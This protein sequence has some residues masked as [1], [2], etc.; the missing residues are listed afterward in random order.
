M[1]LNDIP[2]LIAQVGFPMAIAIYMLGRTDKRL[3]ALTQSLQELTSLIRESI[4]SD[5]RAAP[6]RNADDE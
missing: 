3:D 6:R 5:R 4:G 1:P 2:T